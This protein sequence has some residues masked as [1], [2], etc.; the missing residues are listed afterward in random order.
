VNS[1]RTAALE[2]A[3]IERG[4]ADGPVVMLLHGFPDDARTWDH[5]AE[6]LAADGFRTIAPFVRGFGPSRLVPGAARTGEIAALARDVLALADALGIAAF[7]VI[8][9]DWGARAGYA[10]AAL[11][12]E[13]IVSLTALAVAYGTNVASQALDVHQLRAY[14]YQWYFATPRGAAALRDDRAGFCRDLWRT[15]SPGWNFGEAEYAATAASFENPDFVD[16]VLHSYRVRWGFAASD[17]RYVADAAVLDATPSISVPTVVL[18]GR[19]DG[20]TLPASAAGKER[21]FTASYRLEIIAGSGHFLQREQPEAVLGAARS[22][23]R[24]DD[25]RARREG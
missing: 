10:L 20:A 25:L 12:P 6:P 19:D 11:A 23:L 18:M 9:H 5:I 4:P 24:R 2:C 16:I 7:S 21:F 14:W 8:G 22:A 17:P 3:Y 1:I 15:W 13:R